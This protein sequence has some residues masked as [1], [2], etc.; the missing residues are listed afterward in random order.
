MWP[1]VT[2]ALEFGL[3]LSAIL[4]ELLLG[5]L[6]ANPEIML[7]DYPP[8]LRAKWGPMTERTKQ[9]RVLVAGL[10]FLVSLGV[11]EWSLKTLPGRAWCDVT[12]A[13][14][15]AHFMIIFGTKRSS[16]REAAKRFATMSGCDVM[17]PPSIVRLSRLSSRTRLPQDLVQDQGTVASHLPCTV[18]ASPSPGQGGIVTPTAA[19]GWSP[20]ERN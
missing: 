6:R 19:S 5:V 13:A 20:N 16:A 7:N 18:V 2:H 14:A 9:Q 12:F 4:F 15:F 8:D 3:V 1:I 11:V 17:L 10:L